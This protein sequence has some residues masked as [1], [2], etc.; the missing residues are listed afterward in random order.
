VPAPMSAIA[1]SGFGASAVMT[2]CGFC[3]AS[4]F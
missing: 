2:S 1:A 4:R 3:Q